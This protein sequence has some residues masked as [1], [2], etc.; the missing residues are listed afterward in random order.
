[1][2]E[3]K[4]PESAAII[5]MFA[6]LALIFGPWGTPGG[7]NWSAVSALATLLAVIVAIAVP[8]A[9][10][11]TASKAARRDI[12]LR[13]WITV[14]E[15]EGAWLD[16]SA[17]IAKWRKDGTRPSR[18]VL[19][20]LARTMESIRRY[21]TNTY[22]VAI[23]DRLQR[24]LRDLARTIRES[25]WK[26]GQPTT[27]LE[28]VHWANTVQPELSRIRGVLLGVALAAYAEANKVGIELP[29]LQLEAQADRH[30]TERR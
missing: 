1:M 13:R 15:L 26:E 17:L 11:A 25:P 9:Q 2:R 8:A 20:A 14:S 7:V 30:D 28:A 12:A 6:A 19:D 24:L 29:K 5:S 16:V 27:V 18:E 3:S 4:W 10:H 22:E 23:C 21:S